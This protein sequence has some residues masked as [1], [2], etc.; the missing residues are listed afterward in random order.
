MKFQTKLL[1]VTNHEKRRNFFGFE[2]GIISVLAEDSFDFFSLE[3]P[4]LKT[5]F[6]GQCIEKEN[7]VSLLSGKAILRR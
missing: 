5:N 2:A 4:L 1:K 7:E 3:K 6:F